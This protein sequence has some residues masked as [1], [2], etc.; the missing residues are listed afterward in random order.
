MNESFKKLIVFISTALIVGVCIYLFSGPIIKPPPPIDDPIA[1]KEF[2][3]RCDSLRA[4][5]WNQ[6][7]YMN[8]NG[9][10][11]AMKSNDVFTSSDASNLKIYL[12]QAYSNTLKDSCARWLLTK[13]NDADRKLL[14]EMELLSRY[15]ECSKILTSEISIMKAYFSALQIPA[16]I[17]NFLQSKFSQEQ[18]NRLTSEINSTARKAEIRHFS[19]MIR[20]ASNGN[21]DLNEFQQYAIDFDGAYAYYSSKEVDGVDIISRLCP[22]INPK[23]KIYSYYLQQFNSLQGICK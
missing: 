6:S 17:R 1:I 5:R 14:T 21:N 8:L 4:K 9:A 11:V 12:N 13:G 18:Y 2:K 23:T 15:P 16:K 20:V 10:L 22:N 3:L 7:D 19:S